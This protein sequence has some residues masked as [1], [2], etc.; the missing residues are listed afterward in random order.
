MIFQT[1][2][3]LKLKH[4]SHGYEAQEEFSYYN[5]TFI[6]FPAVFR[7]ND[8]EPQISRLSHYRTIF[9]GIKKSSP[10]VAVFI[11][12]TTNTIYQ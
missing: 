10:T 8:Y 5:H 1:P 4:H 11:I 12:T 2:Q 9:V 7:G 3:L 6:F